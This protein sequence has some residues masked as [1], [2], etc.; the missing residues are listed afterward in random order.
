MLLSKT[1]L[2][3]ESIIGVS[4]VKTWWIKCQLKSIHVWYGD[5]LIISIHIKQQ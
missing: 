1:Y 4:K 3:N 2:Y 5:S